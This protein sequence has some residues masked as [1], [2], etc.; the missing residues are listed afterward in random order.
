MK[1]TRE[2]MRLTYAFTFGGQKYEGKNVV[3]GDTINPRWFQDE[4]GKGKREHKW[5]AIY[6][7]LPDLYCALNDALSDELNEHN[8]SEFGFKFTLMEYE[9]L[10]EISEEWRIEEIEDRIMADAH[11]IAA[12][13]MLA[14]IEKVA[15]WD[16]DIQGDC[17]ADAQKE[18]L[19]LIEK[20]RG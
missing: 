5:S 12:P 14:F 20:V 2:T 18:A 19:E 13:D 16:F 17:V 6:H 8:P 10:I 15:A 9:H 7:E 3:I 4:G 1:E 11:L